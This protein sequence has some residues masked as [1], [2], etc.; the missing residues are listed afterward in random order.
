MR[1][2]IPLALIALFAGYMLYLLLIKKD[3][4]AAAGLLY[5]GLFFIA[6]WAAIYF[7]MLT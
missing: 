4:K 2:V 6:V 5:P 7:L 1:I 3:R